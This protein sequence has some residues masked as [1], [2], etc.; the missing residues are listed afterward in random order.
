MPTRIEMTRQTW[1]ALFLLGLAFGAVFVFRGILV[2][3]AVLLLLSALIALLIDPLARRL[4]R[5]RIKRGTTV[6]GVL[7]VVALAIVVMLVLVT[8]VVYASLLALARNIDGLQ[9]Q[10]QAVLPMLAGGDSSIT[11]TDIIADTLRYL[12]NS[13]GGVLA[14]LGTTFFTLFV[15]VVLVYSLVAEP[16]FSRGAL[17]LLVPA[18]HQQRV[19]ELTTSVS[20]GLAR[21][22][23]AQVAISVYYII[24]YGLIN[25]GLG[26]PFGGTIAVISGVLEFIPYLG[27]IIGMA[28]SIM[29]ALTAGMGY[30]T[31]IWLIVLESI[32]GAVA[33]YFVAP[34]F[35]S[36]AIKVSPALILLGLFIGGQVGGFLAALLTVPVITVIV[37]LVREL[38]GGTA[39]PA[40]PVL[41]ADAAAKAQPDSPNQPAT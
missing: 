7:T 12:A 27:G 2:S 16:T 6:T 17:E 37:I 20:E 15:M 30:T 38:R 34:Y 29:S 39:D 23:V 22:F 41:A 1:L 25:I 11:P 33:V 18:Q 26:I 13:L 8:P 35:F 21:W 4:E 10:F 5:Y 36:K 3:T 19:R 31:I 28:L 24:G 14:S 40:V 9:R 32:L